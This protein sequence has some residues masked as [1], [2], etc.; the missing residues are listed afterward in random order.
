MTSTKTK[1]GILAGL[2][3]SIAGFLFT[4]SNEGGYILKAYPDPGYGWAVPTICAGHTK[5]VKRND[6]ATVEQ[7]DAY[8]KADLE[9]AAKYVRTCI[10]APVTQGQFDAMADFQFNTGKLCQ[11]TLAKKVNA[12]DCWGAAAEFDRWIYSNGKV[13]RGLVKRRAAERRM[14]EADCKK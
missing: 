10:A 4:R 3:V 7:C 14:F 12:G 9:E 2:V 13:L 1:A 5:G 11:S 6:V 8:L